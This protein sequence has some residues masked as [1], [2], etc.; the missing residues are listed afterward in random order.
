MTDLFA[1]K[2]E[3]LLFWCRQRRMFNKAEVMKWGLENYYI[4]ADRSIR[5]FVNKGFIK[6][7]NDREREQLKITGNMAYYRVV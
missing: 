6:R 2:S 3:Q 5:D 4:R 7:L 1:T